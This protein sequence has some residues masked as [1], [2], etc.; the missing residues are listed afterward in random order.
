[1]KKK[2]NARGGIRVVGDPQA[3]VQRIALLPG[4]T[5]LAASLAALPAVDV[6][7]AGEVREWESTEYVRDVVSA[8]GRK[9]LILVGR[10]LSEDAGM[11][12]CAKWIETLAPGMPVRHIPA[13]D[14]YWRPA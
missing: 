9:G 1:L 10:I 4:S 7:V 5:P 14:L 3:R 11:S 2:L 6:I 13:G 12:A 8:G